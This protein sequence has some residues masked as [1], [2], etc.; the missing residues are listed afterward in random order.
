MTFV[1]NKILEVK[2]YRETKPIVIGRDHISYVDGMLAD[3]YIKDDLDG[4]MAECLSAYLH[5]GVFTGATIASGLYHIIKDP[6]IIKKCLQEIQQYFG[7]NLTADQM[8]NRLGD[9]D[10]EFI[11]TCFMEAMRMDPPFPFDTMQTAMED[12]NIE[13]V[14]GEGKAQRLTLPAGT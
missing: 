10:L 4:M 5:L 12:I 14:D 3:K 7:P 9:V 13:S 8:A 2:K 11:D 1:K 6:K